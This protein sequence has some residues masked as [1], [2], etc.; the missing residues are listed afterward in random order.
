MAHDRPRHI[1][2]KFRHLRQFSPILGVFGHRQVGKSTLIAKEVD[3]YRTLDDIDHL[4]LAS[5]GHS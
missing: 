3:D 4:E 2:E 5:Q 1:L